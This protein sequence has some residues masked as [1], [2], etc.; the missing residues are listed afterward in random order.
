M[1]RSQSRSQ[2]EPLSSPALSGL[3]FSSP[4]QPKV[5]SPKAEATK[6]E[7]VV[8]AS[9]D[10]DGGDDD[11]SDG[12]FMD[13]MSTFDPQKPRDKK[14]SHSLTETPRAKRTMSAF[15]SS[16]LTI[17]PKPHLM[18]DMRA[19]ARDAKVD[20]DTKASS[21]QLRELVAEA[22][23]LEAQRGAD[24]GNTMKDIVHDQGGQNAHKVMRAVQRSGD[25]PSPHFHFFEVDYQPSP[26]PTVQGKVKNGPWK[27]LFQDD[28]H[29]KEQY[30]SSGLPYTILQKGRDLPAEVFEWLLDD[31][32]YQKSRLVQQEYCNLISCCPNHIHTLVT[33]NRLDQLFL[34]LGAAG[35]AKAQESDLTVTKQLD[36]QYQRRDW[37]SLRY[38]LKLLAI[39]SQHMS[40]NALGHA[41]SIL[42]K[43]SMDRFLICNVDILMEYE[44]TIGYLLDWL[45]AAEWNPFVSLCPAY[46]RDAQANLF[47]QCHRICTTLHDD[48]KTQN[49]RV[50]ALLSLPISNHRAHELR[51]RLAVTFLF[52]H[53][54]LGGQQ[55]DDLKTMRRLIDRLDHKDFAIDSKT[56]FDE[57]RA[58]II[59]LDIVID[60]GSFVAKSDKEEETSF[61]RDVDELAAKLRAFWTKI[62][63]SGLKLSR[64]QT[65]SVV[66]WVQQRVSLSVRTKR[67]VKKDIYDTALL[68]DDPF[69]PR[70]QTMMREFLGKAV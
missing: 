1:S 18:F 10:D 29:K 67:V 22:E 69:L 48:F 20:D 24:F 21:A 42:L 23:A 57:F 31:L 45:P 6:K 66:E 58:R 27:Q 52:E 47:F 44:A 8:P 9:D 14:P 59:I 61:N 15:H 63:D 38:L 37:S 54:N 50:N 62:N 33:P 65:K 12:G 3:G 39:M 53:A 68:R 49:I 19:L 28:Q 13:L 17:N 56:D 32:C 46:Y 35:E 55:P 26:P 64:A 40:L 2:L 5:A 16:P 43:M 11:S 41:A 36:E 30:L 34:R 60:D 7:L 4:L 51:R 25:Q 70:Q